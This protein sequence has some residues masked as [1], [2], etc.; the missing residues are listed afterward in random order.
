[1]RLA[2]RLASIAASVLVGSAIFAGPL[3]GTAS[4]AVSD[5]YEADVISYVNAERTARGKGAVTQD[6]CLDR[7]AE[8]QAA[9]MASQ[10]RISHQSMSTVLISCD[11]ELVSENVAAGYRGGKE[12]TKGWMASPGHRMNILEGRSVITGVGAVKGT[13]GKWY[14]AQVFGKAF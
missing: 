6:A 8:R 3:V 5:T 1:M 9:K 14:V 12:V 13:D 11:L 10:R 4:A 7:F 2:R